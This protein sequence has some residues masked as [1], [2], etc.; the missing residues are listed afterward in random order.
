MNAQKKAELITKLKA[1]GRIDNRELF[2][3]NNARALPGGGFGLCL[4]SIADATLY[5][6]DTDMAS[7]V[8]R[9]IA[10]IPFADMVSFKASTFPFNPYA[11][12][13]WKGET[14]HL[15]GLSKEMLAAIGK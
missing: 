5:I 8:G 6:S 11:K 14:V 3:F 7:N 15:S 12:F 13:Q 1:E 4:V 9:L 10:A 2:V